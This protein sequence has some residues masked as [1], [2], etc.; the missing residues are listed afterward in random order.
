[1]SIY[2]NLYDTYAKNPAYLT[3]DEVKEKL[4]PYTDQFGIKV[5]DNKIVINQ[6]LQPLNTILANRICAIVDEPDKVYIVLTGSI[7]VLE[8]ESCEVR[9]NLKD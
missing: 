5:E 8:K 2:S 3:L 6:V 4:S 9:I 7:Y 1:M